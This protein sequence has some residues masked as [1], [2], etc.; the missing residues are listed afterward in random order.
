M[1]DF[2]DLVV[3]IPTGISILASTS[4]LV[5]RTWIAPKKAAKAAGTETAE[6]LLEALADGELDA[7][8]L[9]DIQQSLRK[10]EDP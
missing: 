10:E 7:D 8:E 2:S 1:S 6:K 3:A 9:R 4:V 5:Y